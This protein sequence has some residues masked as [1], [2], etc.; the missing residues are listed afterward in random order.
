MAAARAVAVDRQRHLVVVATQTLEVGA[1]IDAEYL[2]TE[3]CGVRAL[4]QRLGRL[5]RLGRFPH[6]R[7]AYVHLPP[8][9]SKRGR[10]A[11]DPHTW[12]VYGAEPAS[13]LERLQEACA[14]GGAVSLSPRQ[15]AEV[16]GP[17]QD[18]PV[19]APQVLPGILW[20]WTKTTTPPEG[21]APVEPSFSGVAGPQYSVQR[22]AAP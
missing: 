6:A 17:P 1:D 21:E 19:R 5:N 16:L 9:K 3:A 8:P 22:E 10:K 4:T 11:A 13:V 20:E 12:P 7:A 2:V 18:L 14:S 15:V